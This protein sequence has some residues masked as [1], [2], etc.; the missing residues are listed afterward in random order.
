[1]VGKQVVGKEHIVRQAYADGNEIGN[2]SW[3]HTDFR[4]LSPADIEVQVK[5]TQSAIAAA[6]VPAPKVIRPPYGA[7]DPMILGHLH[8]A[9]IGWNIDP[10]D[11]K[12]HDPQAIYDNVLASVRPGGIVLMHDIDPATADA[13]EPIL[14]VLK[15]QYQLVTVSELL[16]LTRGD[17][18]QYFNR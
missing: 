15:Q 9:V 16:Q 17:Q 4:K 2:H 13:L 7:V 8:M 10:L 5:L 6:G 11:W 3:D 12:L 14:Q 1:M 18:G